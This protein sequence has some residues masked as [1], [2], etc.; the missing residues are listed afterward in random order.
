MVW[1]ETEIVKRDRMGG[2]R[3]G[4]RA[5]CRGDERT[6]TAGADGHYRDDDDDDDRSD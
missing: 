6:R 2:K 4:R 5:S 3:G 1:R